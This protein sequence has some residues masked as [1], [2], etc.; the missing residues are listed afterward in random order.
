MNLFTAKEL[1]LRSIIK[2][3]SQKIVPSWYIFA[4]DLL[5]VFFSLFIA[6]AVRLNFYLNQLDLSSIAVQ[7]VVI[8]YIY[9]ISFVIFRSYSGII[10]H[11]GFTDALKILQANGTAFLLIAIITIGLRT[12]E[13][14]L[15]RE[16]SLGALV[17][18]FL[19]AYFFMMGA[20]IIVKT[21]YHLIAGSRKKENKKVLIYGAG[22]SGIL[23]L[24]ALMQDVYIS[25]NVAAFVDE[26]Q[27]K[28]GKMLEG[29]RILPPQIVFTK[30][31]IE[32]NEID[33]LIIS[34]QNLCPEKQ[35][36]IV[37]EAL[38]LDLE[39]KVVPAIDKWIN[40][41]LSSEQIRKVKI[42]ELLQ[43]DPIKMDSS[44]VSKYIFGKSVLITG[45]AGSIGSGLVRQVLKY[46]PTK[47]ILLDQAES[48]LYDIQT[49]I[50][51]SEELNKHSHLAEYVIASIKDKFRMQQ[52]F[53]TYK[54]DIIFH[55]AAYKHVPLMENNPYEAL[56]V[57]V[58]GTRNLAD[59]AVKHK[60]KKFVMI[61]TDKAVNPTNVMGAS[62]RI[63]EIYTQ[64]LSNGNTQF[65][66]TR[67]GNVLDSNGSV[68]P[69]FRKQI[70]KG[71]PVTVTHRE[72]TRYFMTIPEACNLVL[73]AGAMG[74][75]GEIFVFDMGR[76][77]K[78]YDMACK[79]IKLS[80][81]EIGKDIE[82]KEIGLRPGEKLYEELL[83]N[84]EN[85]LPTYHPKILRA[86]VREYDKSFIQRSFDDLTHLII[87]ANVFELV[88]KMKE[89]VPE[90]VS[91]NSIYD[92]LDKQKVSG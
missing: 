44:N 46:R 14:S 80:G 69:L 51:N 84:E 41:Q 86:K 88:A 71:G 5:V 49:E 83:N 87:N 76:P 7:S 50:S 55:A 42:E 56:L 54:P 22:A 75:G 78:I 40:G 57:N 38:D 70:E 16:I 15:A 89:I 33:Q 30:D 48:A 65:I 68:V 77:V 25:Y 10:R 85:T 28:V 66:T 12:A 21:T 53:E 3:Y 26:N 34:I 47:L 35:R 27:G 4:F 32:K 29:I 45:A 90:F 74:Q 61:S 43:R 2:K 73:E 23:T 60:V 52:I 13:S 81:L 91:N 39:V 62:K 31:Y 17:I 37:E 82:I 8:T 59:M 9:A 6:Y 36:S 20:R 24:N 11:T 79:M 72:I 19:L 92:V 18:H 64:S 58:F 1:W 67:F 63:A